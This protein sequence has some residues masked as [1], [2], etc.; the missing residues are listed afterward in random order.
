MRHLRALVV[1]CLL[2]V[3]L[4]V[5][6]SASAV[7]TERS[8][9]RELNEVRS[10]Y[11][12]KRLR[13]SRTLLTS[14]GNYANWMMAND[15]FGHRGAAAA[16]NFRATGEILALHGGRRARIR[17]TIR[18]WLNSPSHRAVILAP[19]FRYVGAGRSRGK[20][21]GRRSTAWVAHFGAGRK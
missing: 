5:P 20:F 18:L 15:W 6:V 14:S 17:R 10:S 1:C 16:T 12:L 3:P 2:A 11:G 7:S 19:Q 9:V 13:V 4:A 8:M 21:R